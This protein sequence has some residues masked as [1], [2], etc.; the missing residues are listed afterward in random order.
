M[1][2]GEHLRIQF[3]FELCKIQDA[4]KEAKKEA[5]KENRAKAAESGTGSA[6]KKATSQDKP[7]IIKVCCLFCVRARL[8]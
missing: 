8:I 3:K 2:H 6:A 7:W 1:L 5:R 4:K